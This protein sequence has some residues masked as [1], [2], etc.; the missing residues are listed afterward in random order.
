MEPDDQ[1]SSRSLAVFVGG[2]TLEG[3]EAVAADRDADVLARRRST[4]RHNLLT[5]RDAAGGEPRVG[6]L[7]TIR[8]YALER[9]AQRGDGE[10][11]R[12][13]HAGF[14]AA[15]VEEAELA[16]VGPE[17]RAWVDRLDAERDNLRAAMDWARASGDAEVGLRIAAPLWRF[18][19]ICNGEVEARRRI[20]ELL[21][22][23]SASPATTA[24]GQAGLA[25]LAHILGDHETVR[26]AL[27]ESL[28][29]HRRLGNDRWIAISLGLPSTAALAAGDMDEA[30]LLAQEELE[31]ARRAADP[32][33]ESFGLFHLG[34]VLAAKGELAEGERALEEGVQRRRSSETPEPSPSGAGLWGSWRSFEGTTRGRGR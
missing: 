16:L 12:R 19:N 22:I 17:Q 24:T 13:R 4:A 10:D 25:A 29:V 14:Y 11:V 18:W 1:G 21:A 15:L 3:A 26:R 20:E 5:S 31:T 6:M 2:F 33:G 30:L 8:E 23:G 32:I 34:V 28:P 9:L 7:E 27:S